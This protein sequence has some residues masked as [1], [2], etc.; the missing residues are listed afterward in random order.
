VVERLAEDAD[1]VEQLERP[2]RDPEGLGEPHRLWLLIDD[3]VVDAPALQLAC[4]H[5]PHRAGAHHQH[6]S[7]LS[8]R[9]LL[10]VP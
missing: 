3:Q 6:V 9:Y 4:H 5:Q 2:R 1:L 7:R 8:H 10:A